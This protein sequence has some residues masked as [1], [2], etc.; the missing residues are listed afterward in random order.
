MRASGGVAAVGD[1]SENVLIQDY[2]GPVRNLDRC[3][4]LLQC[5]NGP[6]KIKLQSELPRLLWACAELVT[7]RCLPLLVEDRADADMRLCEVRF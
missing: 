7:A 1:G 2:C 3:L 5:V 4:W 6:F